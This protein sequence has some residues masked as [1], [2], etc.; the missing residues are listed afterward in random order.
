MKLLQPTNARILPRL[1]KEATEGKE[2]HNPEPAG[3][4]PGYA[5]GYVAGRPGAAGT[6]PGAG[7]LPIAYCPLPFFSPLCPRPQ[8]VT[9]RRALTLPRIL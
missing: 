8:E 4:F 2:G 5:G 7:S 1:S 9:A 6:F 3:L